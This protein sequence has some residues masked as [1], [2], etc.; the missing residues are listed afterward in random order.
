[1]EKGDR[2]RQLRQYQLFPTRMQT[3]WAGRLG[4]VVEIEETL[5]AKRLA[6]LDP[7]SDMIEKLKAAGPNLR[8]RATVRWDNAPSDEHGVPLDVLEQVGPV[9]RIAELSD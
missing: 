3:G 1:M 9:D 8:V 2:V 6:Q 7:P 4:T 5:V